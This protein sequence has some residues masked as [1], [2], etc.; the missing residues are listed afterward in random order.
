MLSPA[1]ISSPAFSY[2]C[3]ERNPV[4][5]R[6]L[7]LQNLSLAPH[8]ATS[9][10]VSRLRQSRT[11][12]QS[13]LTCIMQ[14][15]AYA[16]GFLAVVLFAF[17]YFNHTDT[18]K[19]KNLPEIPGVPIFGNLLQLGSHHAKVA[20]SWVKKFGPVFQVRLGNRVC[21]SGN[22]H[23]LHVDRS[24]VANCLCQHFRCCQA[25]MDHKPGGPHLPA[26]A[27]H[28]SY[29]GL[30]LCRLYYWHFTMGRK[31]QAK[32]QD[33]CYSTEST[34][35]AELHANYRSRIVPEHQGYASR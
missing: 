17:R 14:S 13:P 32:T 31:L 10:L 22:V 5:P 4:R 20:G 16:F 15:Q 33:R 34:R 8:L 30:Q 25:L 27:S 28:L 26:E 21:L 12:L 29:R 23:M 35:G 9:H 24:I 6:R 3:L 19:I 11:Q 2:C 7:P 18:P 1:R